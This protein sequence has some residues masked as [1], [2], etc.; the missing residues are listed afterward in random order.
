MA[1]YFPS[2]QI[3]YTI[4]SVLMSL[5]YLVIIL[6]TYNDNILCLYKPYPLIV[7]QFCHVMPSQASSIEIHVNINDDHG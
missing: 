7:L 5:T 2:A 1:Q 6:T 3:H 4:I